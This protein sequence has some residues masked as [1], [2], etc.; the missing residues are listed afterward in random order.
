M[1]AVVGRTEQPKVF[2]PGLGDLDRYWKIRKGSYWVIG[3]DSGS[4]KSALLCN[5]AVNIAR[6]GANIG[7]ISIEMTKD[8]LT[9]RIAAME[10]GIDH[11]RIEDNIITDAEREQIA[12]ALSNRKDI[13]D[14]VFIAD[15]ASVSSDELPGYYNDFISKHDCEV[16]LIDYIQRV[17]SSD[18]LAKS[19]EERV[20]GVSETI[21]AITKATG[22]CTIALSVL[23]RTQNGFAGQ[24]NSGKKTKGLDHLKH[25]GQ[26]GH[27][28]HGVVILTPEDDEGYSDT[29]HISISAVKNRKGRFFTELI[30]L[31]GP[32]QRMR[33]IPK[34][35]LP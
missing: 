4:G 1:N 13:F 20:G 28:A 34:D 15:P 18:K 14:R 22:V 35:P 33:H 19:K 8:E 10:A 17:S 27:D 9:Y 23:A 30:E 5:L 25:S 21:T 29:K 7:I 12:W 32:T 3:G 11:E 24:T 16:V 6:Q 26:I 31:H 2:V